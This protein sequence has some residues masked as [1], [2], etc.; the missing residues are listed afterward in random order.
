MVHTATRP[1]TMTM[2]QMAMNRF[3]FMSS[4]QPR[5]PELA[6]AAAKGAVMAELM[7]AAK[8]PMPKA[9]VAQLP[10]MGLSCS[11]MALPLAIAAV[12]EPS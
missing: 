2:P 1:K 8:R 6:K 11:A 10:R 3:F 12:P 5:M 9:T 4:P 7:P